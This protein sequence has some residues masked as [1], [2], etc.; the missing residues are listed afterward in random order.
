MK[1]LLDTSIFLWSLGAEHKL[2]PKARNLLSSS[3]AELYLSAASS[4][5]IAIKYAFGTLALPKPPSQFVPHAI[6]LLALRSLDITHF[7]SLAAGELPQY[8]RDPIDRMLIAQ[9]R[10]ENMSL[11]TADRTFLKYEVKIMLCGK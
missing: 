10:M 9:A 7:H 2:N 3:A 6:G 1:Y 5:E 4:W 11:L 8:H